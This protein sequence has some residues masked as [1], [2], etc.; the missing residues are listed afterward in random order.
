MCR[1]LQLQNLGPLWQSIQIGLEINQ[2]MSPADYI[3]EAV[4][5][6]MIAGDGAAAKLAGGAGFCI[7]SQPNRQVGSNLHHS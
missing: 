1:Q 7:F 3:S 6:V 2:S 5:P 4:L